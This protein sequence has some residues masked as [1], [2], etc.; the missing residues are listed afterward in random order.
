MAYIPNTEKLAMHGF[1]PSPSPSFSGRE[2]ENKEGRCL[3]VFP[4]D[5]TVWL[6]FEA[7]ETFGSATGQIEFVLPSEHFFD[8]LLL[9]IGW[10][11]E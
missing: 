1:A 8:E 6:A 10:I 4:D 5:Q 2:Y 7:H 11:A 3:T 9:A